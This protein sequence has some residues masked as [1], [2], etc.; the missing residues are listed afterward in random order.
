MAEFFSS[1]LL[2]CSI[3]MLAFGAFMLYKWK[4]DSQTADVMIPGY[5]LGMVVLGGAMTFSNLL[6]FLGACTNV[7]FCLA[8]CMFVCSNLFSNH[9]PIFSCK[10]DI[11]LH[12]TSLFHQSQ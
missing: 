9:M 12:V 7:R 8:V 3:A 5:V 4:N 11:F 6:G 1:I 10:E 2:L